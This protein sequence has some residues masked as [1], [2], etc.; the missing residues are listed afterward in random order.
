MFA[1]LNPGYVLY[2]YG[3]SYGEPTSASLTQSVFCFDPT[4]TYTVDFYWYVYNFLQS[5]AAGI[6]TT[7]C[8]VYVQIAGPTVFTTTFNGPGDIQATTWDYTHST[9]NFVPPSATATLLI[10]ADCLGDEGFI[11]VDLITIYP[12]GGSSGLPPNYE[13]PSPS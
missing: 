11:N 9:A 8:S 10:G 13:Y 12:A 4:Q 2:N 3:Q 1:E 6:T 7:T 5:T